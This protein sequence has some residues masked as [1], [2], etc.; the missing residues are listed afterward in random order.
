MT[1]SK[2]YRTAVNLLLKSA[3]LAISAATFPLSAAPAESV[4]PY[5]I[6]AHV[7]KE[8]APKEFARMREAGIRWMRTDFIWSSVEQKPGEWNYSRLDALIESADE[9]GIRLLPILNYDTPWATPAWKHTNEWNEYVRRTVSRYAKTLRYWEVWNEQNTQKFWKDAP[10]GANYA[11]LLKHS[12]EE[13]KKID[14]ELQVLYGG[15]SH[16]P[17]GYIEDS[18]KAGAGDSF[19]IMNIHP[20]HRQV[21]ELMVPELDELKSLMTRYGVG[22]KPIWITEVGWATSRPQTYF[23]DLLPA[24]LKRVGIEISETTVA[25]LQDPESGSFGE[26]NFDP[27][28]HLANFKTRE[29]VRLH[30]LAELDV[31][32]YPVLLPAI[33]EEFPARHIPDL[34]AYVKRGGTLLLPSGL[35]FY[36]DVQPNKNGGFKRIQV[37][38]RFLKEFHIGWDAWWTQEN[39]PKQVLRY[40]KPASG[41]EDVFTINFHPTGTGRYLHSRNLEPGDEFIPVIE[42]G[43]DTYR[44]AV[45]GIYKLNS[46]LKGNIIVCTLMSFDSVSESDQAKLLP[47]TYLLGLGNGVERIFWY[48]SWSRETRPDEREAHFGIIRKDYEPK[49][50]FHAFQTLIRLCPPGSSVP[51]IKRHGNVWIANWKQPE[52]TPVWALWTPLY[53][54]TVRIKTVGEL[55]NVE[56]FLGEKQP[57]FSEE[58]V[59]GPGVLY[60]VGPKQ[61]VMQ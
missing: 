8:T 58:L 34:V 23:R 40:Q 2:M 57:Q 5:G 45:G 56:N 10:S 13:I 61:I 41:F 11:A 7:N 20:Y 15:T 38:D 29:P 25:I 35:P 37:G 33:G 32:R 21:P 3:L 49:P 28:F 55:E 51:E 26:L 24:A 50:S 19:D 31:K 27:E 47:R 42:A 30:Q 39:V 14:P 48:K 53:E 59:V 52:G 22:H 4:D 18:L 16:V 60:L 44:G 6:C 12:Y 54:E 17:I 43:T 9:G 36:Y 46:E 1:I